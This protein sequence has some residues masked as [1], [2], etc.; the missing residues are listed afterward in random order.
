M[1]SDA[2]PMTPGCAFASPASSMYGDAASSLGSSTSHVFC[3]P[4]QTPRFSAEAALTSPPATP[5]YDAWSTSPRRFSARQ[6][7]ATPA[8]ASLKFRDGSS[9]EVPAYNTESRF[10]DAATTETSSD[11]YV[12]QHNV[13]P[14]LAPAV[15]ACALPSAL[16]QC[17]SL[18]TRFIV[19]GVHA[20]HGAWCVYTALNRMDGARYLVAVKDDETATFDVASAAAAS[21]ASEHV[22]QYYAAWREAGKV[23]VQVEMPKGAAQDL[24][25]TCEAM[26]AMHCDGVAMCSEHI[27]A[28][29]AFVAKNG[30]VKFLTPIL[31]PT[32]CGVVDAAVAESNF[33]TLLAVL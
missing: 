20:T 8:K 27:E 30:Q 15:A 5:V 1:S 25:E 18:H 23:L 19:L 7:P 3:T 17:R 10:V 29:H 24:R 9:L 11:V 32:K 16:P 22:A 6:L 2:I 28:A 26:T 33:T 13:N 31:F 21:S 14:F 4:P 12:E